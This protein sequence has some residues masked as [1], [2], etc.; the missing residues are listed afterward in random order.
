MKERT[1]E[2]KMELL[3]QFMPEKYE[4][5]KRLEPTEA[6]REQRRIRFELN[7]RKFEAVMQ[8][9]RNLEL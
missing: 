5:L 8:G 1:Y 7:T 6:E 4:E 2:E 9:F 3:R